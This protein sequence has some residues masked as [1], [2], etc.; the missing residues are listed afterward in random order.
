MGEWKDGK[1]WFGTGAVPL[2][3]DTP[4]LVFSAEQIARV[5]RLRCTE[6]ETKKNKQQGRGLELNTVWE[7]TKKDKRF[8]RW[9]SKDLVERTFKRICTKDEDCKAVLKTGDRGLYSTHHKMVEKPS[10]G[11]A[12]DQPLF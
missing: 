5:G 2:A 12:E 6:Q 4:L 3:V 1:A 7:E 11:N 8:A 10:F 9:V